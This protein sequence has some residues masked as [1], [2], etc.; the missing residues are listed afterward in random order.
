MF[1]RIREMVA[2]EDSTKGYEINPQE[3]ITAFERF[4]EREGVTVNQ[5]R[6]DVMDEFAEI[7]YRYDNIGS[8]LQHARENIGD[9]NGISLLDQMDNDQFDR[10]QKNHEQTI[11]EIE[12]LN[13]DVIELLNKVDVDESRLDESGR[14]SEVTAFI[15]RVNDAYLVF[16]DTSDT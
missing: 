16:S 15:Q 12:S 11:E 5:N 13:E 10:W 9:E 7:V 14:F 1:D 3:V 2:T 8:E 6:P 4:L